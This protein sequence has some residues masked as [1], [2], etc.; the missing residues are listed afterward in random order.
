MNFLKRMFGLGG[1]EQ[2]PQAPQSHSILVNAYCTVR[3]TPPLDFPYELHGQRDLSDPALAPHVHGFIGYVMS[4]GDGQMTATRYH[5]WRHLQRVRNHLSFEVMSD[6]LTDVEAWGR[7]ANAVFFLP[8][9]SV[10]APDFSLLIAADGQSDPAAAL[11][12]QPD[13]IERKARTLALLTSVEPKPP[14]SMPPAVSAAEVVLKTPAEVLERALGLFY[15]AARAE[16]RHGG[17]EP[18]AAGLNAANPIG[19]A[20]LTPQEAAF[21]S[22]APGEGTDAS[23]MTW[24]YEAANTLFWTLGIEAAQIHDSEAQ[25]DVNALWDAVAH[26]AGDANAAAGLQLR[27]VEDIL[28][29]LDRTWREHWIIRQARGKGIS[30]EGIDGDVVAERHMALNWLT[31]FHNPFGT[32]WDEVDTPT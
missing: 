11:P 5:L 3:D 4:L 20:A 27:P 28:D 26:L 31:S 9:G 30:V 22:A 25:A 17:R 15:V 12:Y 29:A 6:D 18:I 8:D 16:S 24:R 1:R 23:V 14:A 2:E 7:A 19:F 13:T 10:R 32:S 21:V